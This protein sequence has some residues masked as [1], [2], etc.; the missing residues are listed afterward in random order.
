V[1]ASCGRRI[2]EG[3]CLFCFNVSNF[4]WQFTFTSPLPWHRIPYAFLSFPTLPFRSALHKRE[5][6]APV[7]LSA[8]STL[9]PTPSFEHSRRVWQ[10]VVALVV[11]YQ[12]I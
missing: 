8:N 11:K 2:G 3:V 1:Y 5:Y 4:P 6:K 10:E 7:F 12:R 9:Q